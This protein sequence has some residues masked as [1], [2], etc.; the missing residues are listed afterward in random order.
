M[1]V[2]GLSSHDLD[3]TDEEAVSNMTAI[4]QPRPAGVFEGAVKGP[5]LGL[6]QVA[7]TPAMM[8]SDATLPGPAALMDDWFGDGAGDPLLE[9]R[10]AAETLHRRLTPD[11]YTVGALG[12]IGYAL[13]SNVG[14]FVAGSAAGGPVGGAALT[15]SAMGYSR[16]RELQRQGVDTGTALTVGGI[17]GLSTG[18]GGLAPASLG[19]SLSTRLM[20]G[21]AINVGLGVAERGTSGLALR[22]GGYDLQAEQSRMFDGMALIT[23]A[24]LGSAFGALDAGP[25]TRFR[26]ATPDDF[27]ADRAA[28]RTPVLP[29]AGEPGTLTALP[30]GIQPP[31]TEVGLFPRETP[32]RPDDFTLSSLEGFS[33]RAE[34]LSDENYVRLAQRGQP[35]A[36][37]TEEAVFT[38]RREADAYIRE[39]ARAENVE[40]GEFLVERTPDGVAVMRVHDGVELA[41]DP[42]TGAVMEFPSNQDAR[43]AAARIAEREGIPAAALPLNPEPG[44]AAQRHVVLRGADDG[45]A[46]RIRQRPER[47]AFLSTHK[48]PPRD[49][50][51]DWLREN[52][53]PSDVDAALAMND[54]LRQRDQPFHPADPASATVHEQALRLAAEQ[55]AADQPVS[56]DVRQAEFVPRALTVDRAVAEQFDQAL[57][58]SGLKQQAEEIRALRA[59]AERRGIKLDEIDQLYPDVMFQRAATPAPP[60]SDDAGARG[61][62]A[63]PA[64]AAGAGADA[65]GGGRGGDA[66]AQAD[67]GEVRAQPAPPLDGLPR[68]SPGP[69]QSIRD[70]AARYV[71]ERGL[72]LR[73]Q[74]RF[75]KA[76]PE[77]GARIAAA[78]EAMKHDPA[79]PEVA[80]AY[81]AMIDETLAQYQVVKQ[82]GIT[83]EMIPPGAPD[84]YPEGPRQALEDMRNG[85]LWTFPTESGFGTL[86]DIADNPLLEPTDEWIGD[87]RLVANDVFRIV[88]DV[89]GHGKEGVGFGAHG[90]ENAWQSH[91]RMYSPLAARAMTTETRGQNSWVNF[92]PYGD[93][94]RANQKETVFADQKVGLL[95][96]WVSAEGLEDAPDPERFVTPDDVMFRRGDAKTAAPPDAIEIARGLYAVP[97]ERFKDGL[98]RFVEEVVREVQ[99]IAPHADVRLFE[100]MFEAGSGGEVSGAEFRERARSGPRV[101]A[102]ALDS[103]DLR[104]TGYHEALHALH[105]AGLFRDGEWATLEAAARDQGWMERYDIPGRYGDFSEAQQIEEAIAHAVQDWRRGERFTALPAAVRPLI[106]RIADFLQTVAIKARQVFGQQ[107]TADDLFHLIRTGEIGNR[108]S[109]APTVTEPAP[110]RDGATQAS[111][112]RPV[113]DASLDQ[114]RRGVTVAL[115]RPLSAAEDSA[116]AG[117]ISSATATHIT[118][119]PSWPTLPPD[120]KTQLLTEHVAQVLASAARNSSDPIASSFPVSDTP[121]LGNAA[122]SE[123]FPARGYSVVS[124]IGTGTADELR[125]MAEAMFQRARTDAADLLQLVSEA[126]ERP[127]NQQERSLLEQKVALSKRLLASRD[128]TAWLSMPQDQ[129]TKAAAE[130][131][132]QQIVA[133]AEKKKVQIALTIQAH[134]RMEADLAAMEARGIDRQDGLDRILDAKSDMRSGV[135]SLATRIEAVKYD[136]T[137]RL[138]DL[139]DVIGPKVL[140]L[141][142]NETGAKALVYEM[143]G[144]DSAAVA[145]P[146]IARLAKK[147]AE[148]W[149]EVSEAARTRFNALGGNVA[150]LADW[151]F[152]QVHDQL[153]IAKVGMDRWVRDVMAFGL[154]RNR[155]VHED[156]TLMTDQEVIQVLEA[157]YPT[158]ATGGAN[159]KEPLES[160]QSSKRANRHAEHRTIHFSNAEGYLAYQAKYGTG[161]FYSVMMSHIQTMARDIALIERFGPNSDL[162]FDTFNE[163]LRAEAAAADPT[164][165][166]KAKAY[167]VRLEKTYDH[168]A[169]RTLPVADSRIAAAFDTLRNWM[170]ATKLGSAFISSLPDNAT[171][172]LTAAMNGIPEMRLLRNQLASMHPHNPDDLRRARLAGLALNTLIGEVN[173]W[174]SDMFTARWSS[175]LAGFTIRASGLNAVTEARRKAFGTAMMGTIGHLTRSHATLADIPD[176]D[177]RP[178]GSSGVTEADFAVWRLAELEDWGNGN[179]T[180]LTPEAIY[181]IPDA[182]L[183]HLG[184]PAALRREAALKLIGFVLDETN[185][186][187]IVPSARQQALTQQGFQRGTWGGELARTVLLFKGFPIAVVA[188]HLAGRGW[189]GQKTAGGKAAYIGSHVAM[190]TVLGAAAQQLYEFV[191][192]RDPKAMNE[193]KF[194]GGAFLKGGALGIYGDF[195]FN[196]QTSAGN[197]ALAILAGPGASTVDD[198]LNLT[199]GNAHEA[200]RGEETHAGAEAVKFLKNNVPLQN[201]WYTRAITDRWIFNQLQEM[202]S[203]GYLRRVEQRARQEY[204]QEFYWSPRVDVGEIPERPPDLDRALGQ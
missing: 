158:V 90:E 130:L 89:F 127:L 46:Q 173:R 181:R 87:H 180:M 7:A 11:P 161:D 145:P 202:A 86:T 162:L 82:L 53:M 34:G 23:D 201:L 18:F 120:Q 124:D 83:V 110:A 91:I 94:N 164:R 165:T 25:V 16:F 100:R 4:N 92:G 139:H 171:I 57:A 73:Q 200:A 118:S 63:P 104:G 66:R 159:K 144:Q 175:K 102:M 95:P 96:E 49:P 174:G 15:G 64:A 45:V 157:A 114:I 22:H 176:I 166:E 106:E 188:R 149:A 35:A 204:G 71:R 36:A 41:R 47:V 60:R 109:F 13:T 43:A 62:E 6:G 40:R 191:N 38:S 99:R 93:S 80:A 28:M 170:V 121:P 148:A 198:F 65:G 152:P 107:V 88:H 1:S 138:L 169:G 195:L 122:G 55:L 116:L 155:Y 44:K 151:R 185:M 193:W 132:A 2:F 135:Q 37:V 84:P 20:Q 189:Q 150:R 105:R 194:W 111:P 168:L 50:V 129:Q 147:A 146:E 108:E 72:P 30:S 128:P 178:L 123:R 177:Q 69:I 79:D 140:G 98:P 85:H 24:V 156:G 119:D 54:I 141:Y 8:L 154:D 143:F 167:A 5:V 196:T 103:P 74:A 56:V 203:P 163:R 67:E 29:T 75:V 17:T 153:K 19:G 33:F 68:S 78:F 160:G 131:T 136:F 9:V 21:A 59:E 126:A 3:Q 58:E 199:L 27:D 42:R 197:S 39:T 48:P 70:A 117:V 32:P 26:D 183:A 112:G 187:V 101:I 12:Q 51:R 137:R 142:A 172:R 61:Q 14:L 190:S 52:V 125:D 134:D 97:T 182:A 113:P 179:D 192:G 115:G 133:E 81:R 186:A 77:R 76:N 31:G 184:N 10:D